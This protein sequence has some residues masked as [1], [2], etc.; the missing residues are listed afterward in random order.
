[1]AKIEIVNAVPSMIED[2]M[3]LVL[4]M[5]AHYPGLDVSAYRETVLKN[6]ARGSALCALS[7]GHLAGFL[8]FFEKRHMLSCMG[9]AAAYRRQGIG[10]ALIE[11]ML[12]RMPD[13][14]EIHVVTYRADDP[15]GKG[16]RALYQSMGFEPDAL[17]ET[18]GY[19]EQEFILKR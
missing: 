13:D 11:Q 2:W 7:D 12:E 16:A 8:L 14:E 15:M 4:D 18:F 19:P 17:L 9:V 1:M 6:M 3:A 5:R 10:R